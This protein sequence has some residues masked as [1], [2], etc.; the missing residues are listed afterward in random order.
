M[1]ILKESNSFPCTMHQE[2][3]SDEKS[4][5]EKFRDTVLLQRSENSIRECKFRGEFIQMRTGHTT[6]QSTA[7]PGT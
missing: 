5:H 4:G 2:K 1:N 3:V 6:E 7:V